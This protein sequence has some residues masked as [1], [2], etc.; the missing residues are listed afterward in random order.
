MSLA[1]LA[2]LRDKDRS[3]KKLSDLYKANQA[4]KT[5]QKA[6]LSLSAL[7][8]KSTSGAKSTTSVENSLE[9]QKKVIQKL[10]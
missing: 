3:K 8:K 6:C 7:Q 9:Q 10:F 5:P 4:K 1:G 2:K